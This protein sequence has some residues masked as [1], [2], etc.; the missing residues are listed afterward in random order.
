MF[1]KAK[2]KFM[3]NPTQYYALS[4]AASWAG[5]G[6]LM[7]SITLTKTYGLVPSMIWGFGNS[8]A[9]V[10]FGLIAC[11]LDRKSVV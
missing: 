9:C 8:L 7:N 3:N 1:L 10:L 5:V 11:K 6:S 2:R 4:I